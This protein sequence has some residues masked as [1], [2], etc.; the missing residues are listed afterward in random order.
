MHGRG[1]GGHGMGRGPGRG[2]GMGP[3]MGPRHGWGMHPPM[4]GPMWPGMMWPSMMLLMGAFTILL[5]GS[6]PVKLRKTDVKKIEVNTG[7]SVEDL[8]EEELMDTLKRL[9]I[10]KLELSDEDRAQ[11]EAAL[12]ENE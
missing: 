9:E 11:V 6:R 10:E 4:I 2:P 1:F 3:G 12:D 8:T 7:K 5:Y